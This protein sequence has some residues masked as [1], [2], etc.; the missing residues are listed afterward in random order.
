[1]IS[2]LH[3]GAKPPLWVLIL[4]AAEKWGVPPYQI[5]GGSKLL[6]FW[7]FCEYEEQKSKAE[8]TR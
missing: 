2:A 4:I 1:L 5:A 3:Y 6:W 8:Q 7:R